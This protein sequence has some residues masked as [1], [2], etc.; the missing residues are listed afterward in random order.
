MSSA[1]SCDIMG[2]TIHHV[3]SIH[4]EPESNQARKSY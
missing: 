3:S 4:T 1:S 2:S